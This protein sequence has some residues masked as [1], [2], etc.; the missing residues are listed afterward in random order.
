MNS[1][2]EDN[3]KKKNL[4]SSS[5]KSDS[6]DNNDIKNRKRGFGNKNNN[7]NDDDDNNNSRRSNLGHPRGKRP[8]S[9]GNY[10]NERESFRG[11]RRGR[12]RNRGRGGRGR[13]G[14]GNY[15]NNFAS[16]NDFPKNSN[17]N[18]GN[19]FDDDDNFNYNKN[20]KSY[21][22]RNRFNNF[23][24]N[25]FNN[26]FNRDFNNNFNFNRNF[27]FY[28]NEDNFYNENN[29]NRKEK[30][31]VK[32]ES[33]KT[34]FSSL[35]SIIQEN[36]P[37]MSDNSCAYILDIIKSN[38]K[39][40]AFE[41][42][43]DIYV[44]NIYN[45]TKENL[46]EEKEFYDNN[47]IN[48]LECSNFDYKNFNEHKNIILYYKVYDIK[49][50]NKYKYLN[51]PDE[52]FYKDPKEKRRKLKKTINN[53]YNYLPFKCSNKDH[54]IDDDEYNNCI[55][56]HNENEILFHSLNYKCQ[57]CREDDCQF[58]KESFKCN[59]SHNILTDFRKLYDNNND[60]ICKLLN[61]IDNNKK[62]NTEKYLELIE[63]IYE[64]K[65]EEFDLYT[66]KL[67][68]CPNEQEN[69]NEHCKIDKHLC[70]FHH[71]EDDIIR[72][73][74]LFKYNN[75]L[76]KEM[77]GNDECYKGNF[78]NYC[79]NNN[80]FNYHPKNFRKI[81][82]CM[83][84]KRK[85]GKCKYFE[86]CYGIHDDEDDN[87]NNNENE[88]NIKDEIL[89][90][91][92][93]LKLKNEYENQKKILDHFVCKVCK[94]IPKN[95]NYMGYICYVNSKTLFH[96]VCINCYNKTMDK[97]GKCLICQKEIDQNKVV[98]IIFNNEALEKNAN[99]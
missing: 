96:F 31:N 4:D 95:G 87:N 74:L 72:P 98:N 97:N 38:E 9:R 43:N 99:E 91:E 84:Q 53:V 46:N 8:N 24:N 17:P 26:N 78:C 52:Y 28:D 40:T 19:N 21:Y 68:K 12:G 45:I 1:S 62:L 20:F 23:N 56:S 34:E 73:Y 66:F 48:I 67:L 75:S 33:I 11:N 69:F 81:I 82:K 18:F 77:Q 16:M 35:I 61:K 79:H 93:I 15:R 44:Q 30:P 32:L 58:K 3:Y 5:D 13:G 6:K 89:N 51:L 94:K 50:K 22:N 37:L 55:Y 7:N 59:L 64:N 90:N 57:I 14:R 63:K 92:E 10:N 42:L 49:D 41:I 86:T 60:N 88:F 70:F 85:D 76:C 47:N 25:N 65:I 36:F 2:D 54:S 39:K 27:N 71:N 80:E 83:R 29:N